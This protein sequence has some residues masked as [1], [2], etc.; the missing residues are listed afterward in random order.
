MHF[1]DC[2]ET[3]FKQRFITF[4]LLIRS[5]PASRECAWHAAVKRKVQ[6]LINTHWGVPCCNGMQFKLDKSGTWEQVNKNR[7]QTKVKWYKLS[8]SYTF[9]GFCFLLVSVV[10]QEWR[11]RQHW[12]D[13]SKKRHLRYLTSLYDSRC[14]WSEKWVSHRS[15]KG[16]RVVTSGGKM[17]FDFL[18]AIT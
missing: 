10:E 13:G 3:H 15:G 6:T 18:T 14:F 11:A 1:N 17:T 16:T 4:L 9:M 7:G 8:K 5:Q 2:T 12:T